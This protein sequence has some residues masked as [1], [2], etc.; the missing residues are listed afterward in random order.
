MAITNSCQTNER[1]REREREQCATLTDLADMK[2]HFRSRND[3]AP[4]SPSGAVIVSSSTLRCCSVRL[5]TSRWKNGMS[6]RSRLLI[7]RM[8]TEEA[9]IAQP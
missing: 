2:T 9:V 4:G 8:K 1:E 3:L 5:K 6:W 7:A